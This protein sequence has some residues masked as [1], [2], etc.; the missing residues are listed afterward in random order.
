MD[1]TAQNLQFTKATFK[2]KLLS[3]CFFRLGNKVFQQV[4]RISMGS[5]PALFFANLFL[6]YYENKWINKIKQT[7]IGRVRCFGDIFR[8]IHDLTI[9]S[10]CGE[11]ERSFDVIYHSEL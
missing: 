4:I 5:D 3:N 1:N 6:F 2:Q 11:F 9:L 7:D 10:G 8:F